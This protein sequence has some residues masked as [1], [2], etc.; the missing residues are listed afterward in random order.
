MILKLLQKDTDIWGD[1]TELILG[2]QQAVKAG[3][4]NG[5][6]TRLTSD[7]QYGKSAN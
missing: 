4:L 7:M 5:I 3:T 6:I 1:N 2:E